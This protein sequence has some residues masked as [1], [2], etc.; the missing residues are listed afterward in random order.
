MP[1]T[2]DYTTQIISITSPTA[3][4]EIPDLVTAI[5]QSEDDLNNMTYPFVITTGGYD[6][7]TGGTYTAITLTLSD[8]WQIQF[9]NG[10]TLGIVKSGNL[11]GGV[12]GKPVVC[13]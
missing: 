6:D 7:L 3:T 1:I 9:W 4:V 13:F 5:R 11:V 8:E 2:L 12:A 10:V